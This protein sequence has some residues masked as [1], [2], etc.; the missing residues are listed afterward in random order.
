[1]CQDELVGLV[2]GAL[3]GKQVGV[4]LVDAGGAALVGVDA[5]EV[6]GDVVGLVVGVAEGAG[7]AGVCRPARNDVALDGAVV[8]RVLHDPGV[9]G[10]D[11]E[12]AHGGLDLIGGPGLPVDAS[13]VGGI[14]RVNEARDDR[15][16][17]EGESDDEA[18]HVFFFF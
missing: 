2:L 8:T 1:M 17:D 6:V 12:F 3:E 10:D 9:V 11:E 4:G 14:L 18:E 13:H 16:E 15:D 5:A 7:L